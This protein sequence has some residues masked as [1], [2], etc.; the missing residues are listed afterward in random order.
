MELKGKEKIEDNE[1]NYKNHLTNRIEKILSIW[2]LD[3][4]YRTFFYTLKFNVGKDIF[5]G[6][7]DHAA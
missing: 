7:I 1:D 4:K 6:G 3:F 2:C 5:P